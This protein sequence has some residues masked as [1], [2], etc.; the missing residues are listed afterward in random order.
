[1]TTKTTKAAKA[2]RVGSTVDANANVT[3]LNTGGVDVRNMAAI[4]SD[5]EAQNGPVSRI[6]I[7]GDGT[8]M[9]VSDSGAITLSYDAVKDAAGGIV[10]WTAS[11]DSIDMNDPTKSGA[12][13]VA[14]ALKAQ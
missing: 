6:V 10:G 14:D 9:T 12:E 3:A 5:H 4:I 1:M 11:R 2:P 7:K 13:A 8:K